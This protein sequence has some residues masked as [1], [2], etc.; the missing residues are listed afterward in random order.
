MITQR[1]KANKEY[2]RIINSISYQKRQ[3]GNDQASYW[4]FLSNGH[5]RNLK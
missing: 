4:T 3:S 2:R 1:V 5:K